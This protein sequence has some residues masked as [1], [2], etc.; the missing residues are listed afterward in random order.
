MKIDFNEILNKL[1]D[2]IIAIA[3][4]PFELWQLLPIGFRIGVGLSILIITIIF[5]ILTMR[6]VIKRQAI[7]H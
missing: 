1:W 5:G 4:K 7:F 2:I 3:S 6:F